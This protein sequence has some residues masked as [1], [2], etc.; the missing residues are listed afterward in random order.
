[1]PA[2]IDAAERLAKLTE[3]CLALP[4]TGRE[5]KGLRNEHAAFTVGKKTF[6]WFVDNHHGD[7]IVGLWCKVLPGENQALAA[8]DP[9]RFFVPPYVGKQGWVGF[10]LD[11]ARVDWSEV[12]ELVQGSY[13]MLA[14]KKLLD[15]LPG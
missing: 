13:R 15:S 7:G 3:L 12:R 11:T 14:G 1:M 5:L 9:R 6:V 10:R 4:Q 8:A 2:A